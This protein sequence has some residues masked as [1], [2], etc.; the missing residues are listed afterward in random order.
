MRPPAPAVR[1]PAG[2]RQLADA[3][4]CDLPDTMASKSTP[5][6]A[7]SNSTLTKT[8]SRTSSN[9][10]VSSHPTTTPARQRQCPSW[11]G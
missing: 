5:Q 7:C 3:P 9:S 2:R 8:L 1:N 10:L 6:Y 4:A 11:D